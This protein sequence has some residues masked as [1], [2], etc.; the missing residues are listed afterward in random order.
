MPPASSHTPSIL[1]PTSR[2][3]PREVE[4]LQLIADGRTIG[5]AADA[6]GI[7][8]RTADTHMTAIRQKKQVGT[9]AGAVAAAMRAGEIQ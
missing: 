5:Q 3:T 2:L 8:P 9:S 1:I 6:L 4:V 7:A